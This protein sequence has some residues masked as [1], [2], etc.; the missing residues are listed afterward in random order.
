[1]S[2]VVAARNESGTIEK[3]ISMI[4]EQDYPRSK[5]EVIVVDDSSSDSTA[6]LV[7]KMVKKFKNLRLYKLSPS[8]NESIGR[9]PE[10]VA[11]AVSVAKGEIILTTDADCQ[12]PRTW[13]KSMTKDFAGDVMFQAGPVVEMQTGSFL[14]EVES[15]EFMSLIVTGAGLIGAGR[16]IICNGANL[17]Y[18]KSAFK[19]VQGFEGTA[20]SN[21]DET[22]MQ[23]ICNRNIGKVRFV[24]DAEAVVRTMSNNNLQSFLKQRLRWAAKKGRY[25]DKTI[26]AELVLLYSFFFVLLA[27]AGASFFVPELRIPV[28]MMFGLKIVLDYLAMRR[29]AHLLKQKLNVFV[30]LVAELF[31]VPYIVFSGAVGQFVS[32][33]WKGRTFDR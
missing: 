5:F 20:S 19:A 14:N 18:R 31:H 17:A 26:L 15:L 11:L 32:Q 3:C 8:R 28:V 1:M 2:V 22:L 12:V 6:D 30:F 23:R 33:E 16:P 24:A 7:R 4:L 9:K 29:G 27:S 25:E 21:D 10:S 13:L